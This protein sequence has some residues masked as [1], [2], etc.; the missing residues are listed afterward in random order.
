MIDYT[1]TDSEINSIKSQVTEGKK[2][3]RDVL[4]TQF[5]DANIYIIRG[6]EIESKGTHPTFILEAY[7]TLI[8]TIDE[9]KKTGLE[10]IITVK[11]KDLEEGKAKDIEMGL[12]LN[13]YDRNS[14]Y[15]E[16]EKSLQL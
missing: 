13:D 10:Y 2:S 7:L 9:H 16:L 6:V 15:E 14:I 4:R 1:L 5:P 3:L 11:V 8:Q 12:L